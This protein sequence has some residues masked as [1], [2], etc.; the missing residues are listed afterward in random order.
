MSQNQVNYTLI[1][2]SHSKKIRSAIDLLL[3]SDSVEVTEPTVKLTECSP[4]VDVVMNKQGGIC[5]R[6]NRMFKSRT[7]LMNHL[8]KCCTIINDPSVIDLGESDEEF[9]TEPIKDYIDRTE[10]TYVQLNLIPKSA[11]PCVQNSVQNINPKLIVV[12]QR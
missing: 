7:S 12:Q 9:I 11:M 8:E 3:S 6:C 10:P 2:N 4:D 5:T 1:N